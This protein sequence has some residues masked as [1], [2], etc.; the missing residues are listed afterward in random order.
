MLV[1][2]ALEVLPVTMLLFPAGQNALAAAL[3]LYNTLLHSMG[4]SI[5]PEQSSLVALVLVAL[6]S[7]LGKSMELSVRARQH[8]CLPAPGGS[9]MAG[10]GCVPR[11]QA[12]ACVPPL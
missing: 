8:A 5:T 7:G 12:S 11:F 6:I 4:L 10:N 3:G 9:H 1:M 2:M